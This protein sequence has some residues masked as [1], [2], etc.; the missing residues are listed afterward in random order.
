MKRIFILWTLCVMGLTTIAQETRNGKISI[1]IQNHLQQPLENATVELLRSKDS[2]LVKISLTDKN[3]VQ[4]LKI[5]N[6][7]LTW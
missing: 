1:T 4:N 6:R 2:S 3:G 7:V 5:S